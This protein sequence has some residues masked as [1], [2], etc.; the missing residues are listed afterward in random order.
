MTPSTTSRSS[1]LIPFY[2]EFSY[3]LLSIIN[4]IDNL[5]PLYYYYS[6][7]KDIDG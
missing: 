5:N 4:A 1:V 2:H 6:I 3:Q 7:E